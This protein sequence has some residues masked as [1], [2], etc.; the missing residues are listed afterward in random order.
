[1]DKHQLELIER[2]SNVAPIL[3]EL[4]DR[5]VISQN[6]YDKIGA[7]PT[8]QEKMRAICSTCLKAGTACKDVFYK[9]L[10]ENE[11]HLIA[12]LKGERDEDVLDEEQVSKSL[13][14]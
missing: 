14:I 12:D 7:L 5:K 2:V 11:P 3:D 10:E 4:L 13:V 1:M 8:S 9:I 6:R